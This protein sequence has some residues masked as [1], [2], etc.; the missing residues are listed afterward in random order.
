MISA[1]PGAPNKNESTVFE[2]SKVGKLL[3]VYKINGGA[4]SNGNPL[5]KAAG[6]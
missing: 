4:G 1:L 3:D 6:M 2:W 5:L